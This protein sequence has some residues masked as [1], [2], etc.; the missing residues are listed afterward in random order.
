MVVSWTRLSNGFGQI[1]NIILCLTCIENLTVY[2]NEQVQSH[3]QTIFWSENETG[4]MGGKIKVQLNECTS[5]H[6]SSTFKDC[7]ITV[8]RLSSVSCNSLQ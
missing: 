3:S 5:E 8:L 1:F 2:M 7:L 6:Y 4:V